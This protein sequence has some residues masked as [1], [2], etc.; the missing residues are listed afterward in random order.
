V[1]PSYV[2][3]LRER[4]LELEARVADACARAG[5]DASEVEVVAVSKTVEPEGLLAAIEAGYGRFGENR[6]QELVHK[7]AALEQAGLAESVRMDMI[8]NLQRNKINQVLGRAQLIHSIS[9]A[10]LAEGVSS[11]AEARGLRELRDGLERRGGCLPVLSCGMSDDFELAVEEGSTLVRLG[12]VV[13]DQGYTL[14]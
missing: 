2:D 13:F 6:P 8:G 11:R 9:S 1:G 7:T 10:H 4:R 14:D 12:R 3:F 5:R